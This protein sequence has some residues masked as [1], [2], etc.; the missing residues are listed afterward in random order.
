MSS[1]LLICV[2]CERELLHSC[3]SRDCG[4]AEDEEL[5]VLFLARAARAWPRPA[6]S[7]CLARLFV[8]LGVVR[9]ECTGRQR[10]SAG[11]QKSRRHCRPSALSQ[12]RAS[13]PCAVYH[14]APARAIDGGG[15]A[16]CCCRQCGSLRSAIRCAHRRQQT[17][18][19][20]TPLV[21][22]ESSRWWWR[23]CWCASCTRE[24]SDSPL[25]DTL[26]QRVLP[27]LLHPTSAVPSERSTCFLSLS[28]FSTRLKMFR[29]VN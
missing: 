18:V 14:G 21:S 3:S 27:H 10:A 12:A 11:Q 28:F 8:A 15:Q 22:A 24:R 9:F 20:H 13:L 23:C 16:V 6:S 25:D 1:R 5:V 7:S 26:S 19:V 2:L 4:E 17:Q 29:Q